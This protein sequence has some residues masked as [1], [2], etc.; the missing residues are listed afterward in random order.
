MK[1][2]LFLTLF[3]FALAA[4]QLKV[5]TFP[6]PVMVENDSQGVFI[7]L[8]KTA[9]ADAGLDVSIT[10]LPPE[11]AIGGFVEKKHDMLFPGLDV[12][13]H[14]KQ[15]RIL[16]SRELIY[17][18]RDFAF[19]KKGNALTPTIAS[20]TGTKKI[21]L[22]SGYPYAIGIIYNKE[23]VLSFA[24]SDEA[25]VQRLLSGEID[26]FVVEE[27]SGLGAIKAAD[28]LELVDYDPNTP[29][30]S[31]NVFFTFHLTPEM[32]KIEEK[33]SASLAKMKADGRFG[34]IMDKAN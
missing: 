29:I 8:V 20:M 23:L 26:V 21:G 13:F 32:Q 11:E 17:K 4:E 9:A 10:V 28:A 1:A 5:V 2:L 24:D 27:K 31:Q 34:A 30:T 7:E 12:Q 22:T 25:N 18:K 33:F 15:V 16:R 14:G 3:T 19:V 6:I